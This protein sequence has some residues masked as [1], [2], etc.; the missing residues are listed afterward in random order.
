MALAVERVLT[1]T[2]EFAPGV[3]RVPLRELLAV[4]VVC[5]FVQG[6]VMGLHD[7]R[8]MQGVYS[9]I[10]VPLLLLGSTVVCVPSFYVLHLG[11]SL[12]GDF[13]AACRAIF[14]VQAVAAVFLAACAPL[15]A[16][17]YVSSDHYPFAICANGVVY[18]GAAL[19]AQRAL[20]RHYVPLIAK[21]RRHRVTLGAFF[22]LYV[23]VAIQLA[24]TLRPF[25]GWRGLEP[26]LFRAEAWGN[27]YVHVFD[28]VA[29]LLRG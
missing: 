20:A 24:W 27:A 7:G 16:F 17:A 14:V 21:D 4:V 22:V 29:R 25:I 19:T 9:G 18:L 23:L 1:S 28:T 8:V 5:G 13:M 15:I 11:L 6:A 2:G 10:K 3:G 26:A 12:H